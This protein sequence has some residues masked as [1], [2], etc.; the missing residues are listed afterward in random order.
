MAAAESRTVAKKPKAPPQSR[1][2][3][4]KILQK[5]PGKNRDFT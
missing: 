3:Y 4:A 2:I 5:F 1:P